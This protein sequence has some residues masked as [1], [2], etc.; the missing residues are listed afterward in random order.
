MNTPE[1]IWMNGELVNWQDAKIHILSHVIHYGS[2]TFEGIR[3]YETDKGSAILFFEEHIK[4]LYQSSKI[5]RIEIPYSEAELKEA[6]LDTVRANGH[7]ACYIRPLVTRG[8]GAL[9][10]NPSQASIEVAIATWEWGTYLGEEVLE[11]GVDVRVSS[12]TRLAPNTLPTWSKA[13]GNYLNSQLIK[14]EALSDNYAEGIG[15]DINGYVAEGSGENIFVIRDGIIYTPMAGQ[16]ILPGITRN[17]VISLAKEFGY[18]L[19]ETLIP[20]EALYIADE[21][22]LTGTAAEIT[23][24]RSVDK[25]PVGD[26][27]RGPITEK[28]QKAYLD[29]V[30]SGNDPHNWLTFI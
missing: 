11:T 2:S 30:K 8:Q 17:A 18:E 22:F 20:R 10:V 27:K 5:Y 9:G 15:L 14:L 29:V 25:Y 4:R 21:I 24:V 3:C 7:K 13:G 26:E 28:L 1:K 16:S 12:W 23:P 6:I 19:R